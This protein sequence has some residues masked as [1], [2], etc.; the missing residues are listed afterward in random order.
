MPSELKLFLVFNDN[1]CTGNY[2]IIGGLQYLVLLEQLKIELSK[3]FHFHV[4]KNFTTLLSTN[5][6]G[7]EGFLIEGS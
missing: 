7:E 4:F 3:Q 1:N 2:A 6:T 5:Q